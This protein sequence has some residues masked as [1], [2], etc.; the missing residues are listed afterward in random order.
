MGAGREKSRDVNRK[1]GRKGRRNS[2]RNV[3]EAGRN[4]SIEIL[5]M[6]I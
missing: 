1:A 2:G 5:I 6:K 3:E 4:D